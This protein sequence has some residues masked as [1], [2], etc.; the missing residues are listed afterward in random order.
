MVRKLKSCKLKTILSRRGIQ[1]WAIFDAP[2]RDD[3]MGTTTTTPNRATTATR[4]VIEH[5]TKPVVHPN[6]IDH[7]TPSTVNQNRADYQVIDEH[8]E[9]V[10]IDRR[11][12]TP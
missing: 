6:R 12:Q 5:D 8:P 11:D 2:A 7:D 1:D 10:I 9:V 4:N 3:R